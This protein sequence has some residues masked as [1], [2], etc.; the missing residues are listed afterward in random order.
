M[1][2]TNLP[3]RAEL[4]SSAQLLRSTLLAAAIAAGLLVTT[5]LPAEYGIDPT[6][7]GSA[8]G[9]TQMGEI[10]TTLAAE[11]QADEAPATPPATAPAGAPAVAPPPPSRRRRRRR[12]PRPKR[13]RRL[14]PSRS[15]RPR[16]RPPRST[17]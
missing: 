8:L 17:P 11:K 2:N 14:L 7:V 3:N 4:P 6:G 13:F 9:L 10:K 15:R 16:P 1:Y 12:S 5:I